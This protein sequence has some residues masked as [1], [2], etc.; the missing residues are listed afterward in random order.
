MIVNR[1]KLIGFIIVTIMIV[2]ITSTIVHNVD[3][4]VVIVSLPNEMYN[5]NKTPN[6]W[7]YPLSSLINH[8]W[9]DDY[10]TY[11]DSYSHS[12]IIRY[13]NTIVLSTP[14]P[15]KTSE[16][17]KETVTETTASNMTTQSMMIKM[18]HQYNEVAL[19]LRKQQQRNQSLTDHDDT[20]LMNF[21]SM[22]HRQPTLLEGRELKQRNNNNNDDNRSLLF[23]QKQVKGNT[24]AIGTCGGCYCIPSLD[25]QTC[26]IEYMPPT[27]YSSNMI[28]H[29]ENFVWNNTLSLSCNPYQDAGCDTNEYSV[30]SSNNNNP[31][32]CVI[33]FFH[34][35]KTSTSSDNDVCFNTTKR[36][37]S[38]NIRTYNGSMQD[39]LAEGL[40]VTH[41]NSCGLCSNLHDL[42]TYMKWG[43][44]LRTQSQ[45]CGMIGTFFGK[46]AAVNCFRKLGF[47]SGCSTIWYYNTVN[48]RSNC[49]CWQFALS[50]GMIPT[51]GLP[52]QCLLNSCLEC[53][54]TK[55]GPVFRQ[56]AGRTRRNSAILSDF[57]R[58]CSDI[59]KLKQVDPCRY[60]TS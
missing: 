19:L 38:Y 8:T 46:K 60:I 40:Y 13:P 58:S 53:D 25:N 1:R 44:L 31:S 49:N 16:A 51:N 29:L 7:N 50:F 36:S 47:T 6:D 57:A 5:I 41:D 28:Q 11:K 27:S 26:P 42:A 43:T 34:D 52:P 12:K 9:I 17:V 48:T 2:T 21:P 35:N 14:A 39:A 22:I 37:T 18:I 3:D 24:S 4:A 45:Q 59:A 20:K 33:D 55:S 56:F 54:E 30:L 23:H 32:C 15:S 10:D